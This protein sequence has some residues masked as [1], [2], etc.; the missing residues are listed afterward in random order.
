MEQQNINSSPIPPPPG[1][2]LFKKIPETSFNEKTWFDRYKYIIIYISIFVV[3]VAIQFQKYQDG[4]IKDIQ[5]SGDKISMI[6]EN[7]EIL[8]DLDTPKTMSFLVNNAFSSRNLGTLIV[9]P[10]DKVK[11]LEQ[12]YTDFTSCG[13]PGEEE[14]KSSIIHIGFILNNP[15]VNK[16]MDKISEMEKEGNLMIVEIDGSELKNLK[17]FKEEKIKYGITISKV[18]PDTY[19]LVDNIKII[20]EKYK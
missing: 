6:L 16:T 15:D 19:Y 18:K 9:I 3:I 10:M 8:A 20:K 12:K 7:S 14:G 17:G 11:Y 4:G 2:P 13:S 1:S 5:V